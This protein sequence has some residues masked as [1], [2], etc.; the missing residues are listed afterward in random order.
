MSRQGGAAGAK[1]VTK[2]HEYEGTTGT[3]TEVREKA[4]LAREEEAGEGAGAAH[5]GP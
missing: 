4:S 2:P 3:C 5:R 1:T